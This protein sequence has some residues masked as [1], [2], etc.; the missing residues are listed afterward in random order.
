[1]GIEA[2]AAVIGQPG[3]KVGWAAEI[4]QCLGQGLQLLQW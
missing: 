4:K 2:S 3:R 1:M